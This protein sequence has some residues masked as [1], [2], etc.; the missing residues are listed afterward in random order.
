MKQILFIHGGDSYSDHKTYLK[1]LK[2]SP[3]DYQRIK[4]HQHWRNWIA[5]K[6]KDYDVLVPTMPN[7]FNAKYNEWVIWF[8]K[9]I[10]Y[11]QNDFQIIGHSLGAMFLAKYLHAHKLPRKAHRIVLISGQY[12][13]DGNSESCGSFVVNSARGIEKSADEIHL[14]HSQDDPLVNFQS[15]GKFQ[16]DIPNS[17]VHIFKDKGHFNLETFPE[18]LDILVSK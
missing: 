18:L 15:L 3:L 9:I 17:I 1:S 13:E 5:K 12:G 8:E 10:P 4:Y 16:S 14:I 6:L 2:N 11:M 7:G